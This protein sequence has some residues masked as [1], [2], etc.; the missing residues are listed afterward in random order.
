MR[1]FLAHFQVEYKFRDRKF[2]IPLKFT[3]DLR[4][5]MMDAPRVGNALSRRSSGVLRRTSHISL[6][7]GRSRADVT[8]Q[9]LVSK[10]W[11][12]RARRASQ[13]VRELKKREPTRSII[14]IVIVF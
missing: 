4:I 11:L 9:G 12:K 14:R 5:V 8:L 13:K 2:S 3:E 6:A 7:E 10:P 1:L